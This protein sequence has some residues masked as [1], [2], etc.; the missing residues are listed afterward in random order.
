MEWIKLTDRLPKE[1]EGVLTLTNGDVIEGYMEKNG[2]EIEWWFISL[3]IHGC[4]C[5]SRD[6]DEVTHWQP[7]PKA[8]K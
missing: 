1:N 4:G 8:P 7:L 3:Q 2:D 5:C 6:D